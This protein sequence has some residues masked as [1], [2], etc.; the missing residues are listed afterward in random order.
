M[1]N[2]GTQVHMRHENDD[3]IYRVLGRKVTDQQDSSIHDDTV[4]REYF[5]LSSTGEYIVGNI[6]VSDELNAKPLSIRWHPFSQQ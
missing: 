1:L 5:N 3:V 6:F 4:V 2:Y